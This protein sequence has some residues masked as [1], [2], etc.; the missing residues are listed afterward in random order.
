MSGLRLASRAFAWVVG[1][2]LAAWAIA[3]LALLIGR[4]ELIYPFSERAN[5]YNAAAL[6]G[7]EVHRFE[8]SDGTELVA[9][10]TPPRRDRPV[11]LFFMGNVGHLPANARRLNRLVDQGFGIA[12]LNFRGAGGAPGSPSEHAI[13]EDA[14][15]LYDSLD[16]M[17]GRTIPAGQ[18]V[19]YGTSLGAAVAA[20][21]ALRRQ[22]GAVILAAPFARLCE[23]GQHHYPWVPVCW[24]LP[25]NRWNT[26]DIV[27]ELDAPLLVVHGGADQVVPIAQAEALVAAAR[28]PTTF[29]RYPEGGHADLHRFGSGPDTVD[30]LNATLG[31]AE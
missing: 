27:A 10:I 13:T 19:A 4:Q 30:W 31:S 26:L 28:A 11:I 14:V 3:V 25:D 23:V 15:A 24:V 8:A 5:A 22:I 7:G 1:L 17:L 6:R 21:L 9:W 2:A 18:R 29:I 12:A 20:Q 16:E